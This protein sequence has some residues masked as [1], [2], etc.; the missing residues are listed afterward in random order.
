MKKQL[1]IISIVA[2]GTPPDRFID[3]VTSSDQIIGVDRGALWLVRHGIVPDIGVGDFDSVIPAEKTLIRK[4]VKKFLKYPPKKDATDLELAVDEAIKLFPKSVVIYGALGG[5]FDHTMAAVQM[6]LRLESHNISGQIVDNFNKI[7]VVRRH[8]TLTNAF[9]YTYVS[10]IPL[11]A[12]A[13]VT[14]K[15]FVYN[16]SRKLFRPDSSLGTSNK[17][18][19][20]KATIDVHDGLVLVVH[21]SDAGV[22]RPM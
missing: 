5:R 10:I 18:H 8:I 13:T 11:G 3:S 20:L 19:K 17:I 12:Q 16:A 2:G 22:R 1:K 9:D 7:I 21:S 6:L 15:G 14:L 4:H